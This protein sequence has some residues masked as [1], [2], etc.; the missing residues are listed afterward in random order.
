LGEFTDAIALDVTHLF[1]LLGGRSMA[2]QNGLGLLAV[3]QEVS[4]FLQPNHL[5]AHLTHSIEHG[6]EPLL[7]LPPLQQRFH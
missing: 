2:L 4:Y 3:V 1:S 6:L 5:R 7:L